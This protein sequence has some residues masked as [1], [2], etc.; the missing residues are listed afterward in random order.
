[1][2]LKYWCIGLFLSFNEWINYESLLLQKSTNLQ[3]IL[4]SGV[5]W[6]KV[7]I[8]KVND[9]VLAITFYEHYKFIIAVLDSKEMSHYLS[10][11]DSA[12][13]SLLHSMTA[14][15]HM[16]TAGSCAVMCWPLGAILSSG[17]E[18]MNWKTHQGNEDSSHDE[19]NKC[20]FLC[21]EPL[22]AQE[23]DLCLLLL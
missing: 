13:K 12:L 7:I 17:S 15:T 9:H 22:W 19:E 1:M 21:S 8:I 20:I 23:G 6:Y 16:M 5:N 18:Q 4:P 10:I 3:V 14:A 2:S 11:S